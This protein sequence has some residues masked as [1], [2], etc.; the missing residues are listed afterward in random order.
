MAY[1]V[2]LRTRAQVVIQ[3]ATAVSSILT[4][5]W[6]TVVDHDLTVTTIVTLLA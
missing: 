6:E 4:G 2:V 5:S 1:V 3:E